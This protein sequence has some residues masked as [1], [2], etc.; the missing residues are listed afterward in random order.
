MEVVDELSRRVLR[1]DSSPPAVFGRGLDQ[2]ARGSHRR[3]GGRWIAVEYAGRQPAVEPEGEAAGQEV[4]LVGAGRVASSPTQVR[5][6]CLCAIV[7]AWTALP[8]SLSAA[9]LMNAHP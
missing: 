5:T 1:P 8:G 6:A 4:G 7:R 2:R 3:L 9:V